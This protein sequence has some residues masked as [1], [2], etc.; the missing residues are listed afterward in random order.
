MR[1]RQEGANRYRRFAL[2][3]HQVH[4]QNVEGVAML[5]AQNLR[6]LIHRRRGFSQKFKSNGHRFYFTPHERKRYSVEEGV[7]S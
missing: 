3:L 2:N 6:D 5:G 4:P 7:L 1:A